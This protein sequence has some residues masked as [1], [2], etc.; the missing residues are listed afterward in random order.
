MLLLLVSSC[1][2]CCCLARNSA[3]IVLA[4]MYA[5]QSLY[6]EQFCAKARSYASLRMLKADAATV[7]ADA[8]DGDTAPAAP[9]AVA[10]EDDAA[11]ADAGAGC[12]GLL[13]MVCVCRFLLELL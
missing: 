1:S 5:T 4:P 12:G 6:E 11:A 8:C 3:C 2:C 10:N 9:L 7:A 13:L